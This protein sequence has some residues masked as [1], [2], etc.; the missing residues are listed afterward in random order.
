MTGIFLVQNDGSLVE[1]SEQPYDSEDLLQQLLAKYPR[2]L[3]G[4]SSD[5]GSLRRWLLICREMP[6]PS[7]E[8]G[9][10]RWSLDH[11]FLDQDAIPTLIEVKRSS[12]TRIRR[13][14]VGQLLDYAANAVSYW[15]V[16]EFCSHFERECEKS[17]VDPA[18]KLQDFLGPDHRPEDFW[19][20]A[21]TNLQA[22]RI[23]MVFVADVIPRELRRIVEFLNGQMDPAEVLA[24]EIKQFVGQGMKTLV[25][26][27]IGQTA[28][29]E[30]KKVVSRESRLWDESSFF[31]ELERCQPPQVAEAIRTLFYRLAEKAANVKFG[32]G[33]IYATAYPSFDDDRGR[34]MHL[35]L[36]ANDGVLTVNL[37]EMKYPPFSDLALQ[38]ELVSRFNQVPGINIPAD[39]HFP[40]LKI[41]PVLA[42]GGFGRLID[43]VDWLIA[44]VIDTRGK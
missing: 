16:E 24:I 33:K 10:D 13:E 5:D 26:K 29:A 38:N 11:L 43:V 27:I 21:K 35:S 31:A 20:R 41:A 19:Q 3:S 15:P 30:K 6:V 42:K 1:M 14:V 44:Q 7:E 40:N 39:K 25:P 23:R 36:N 34:Q 37:G 8:D 2:L 28:E 18:G 32:K 22:G 12:D 17:G 9:Y 4:D